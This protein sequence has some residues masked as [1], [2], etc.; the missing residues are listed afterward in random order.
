VNEKDCNVCHLYTG[1][2]SKTKAIHKVQLASMW[3]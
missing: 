2:P 3:C 1:I